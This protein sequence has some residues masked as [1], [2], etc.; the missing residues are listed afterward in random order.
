[1]VIKRDVPLPE[2]PKLKH[3]WVDW[4]TD[5]LRGSPEASVQDYLA[6]SRGEF[7]LSDHRKRLAKRVEG[8]PHFKRMVANHRQFL[9]AEP[10]VIRAMSGSQLYENP[11]LWLRGEP[12]YRE[13]LLW[14]CE[15][16]SLSP[17]WQDF[18]ESH[19]LFAEGSA[20]HHLLQG[21][22]VR[23][24]TDHST[25][26]LTITLAIDRWVDMDEIKSAISLVIDE[27]QEELYGVKD[28]KLRPLDFYEPDDRYLFYE[29]ADEYG[30]SRTE[31]IAIVRDSRRTGKIDP[32]IREVYPDKSDEELAKFLRGLSW[33]SL[34]YDGVHSAV[35][36]TRDRLALQEVRPPLPPKSGHIK[37]YRWPPEWPYHWGPRTGILADFF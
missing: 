14:Q 1:M 33:V 20:G 18:I 32:T 30:K 11:I 35:R 19:V 13:A 3:R 29:L 4:F 7:P 16:L 24:W 28:S 17:A 26:L 37:G 22:I 2:P 34:T 15:L 21:P 36:H 10:D 12:G 8:N 9:G 5:Y 27:A 6:W 31:I 23:Y 25:R